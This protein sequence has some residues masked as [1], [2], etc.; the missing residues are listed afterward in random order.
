[1]CTVA[2]FGGILLT[3]AHTT[4]TTTAEQ[5]KPKPVKT[6]I[7]G[8]GSAL[9]LEPGALLA[10]SLVD[11]RPTYPVVSPALEKITGQ[12]ADIVTP[13]DRPDATEITLPWQYPTAKKIVLGYEQGGLIS[14]HFQRFLDFAAR[15]LDV[16]ITNECNSA[17]TLITNVIRKDKLCFGPRAVLNFHKASYADGKVSM[18]D[19]LRMFDLY[20][21]DIRDWINARGGVEKLP[22]GWAARPL[23][24]SLPASELWKMGC[25]KCP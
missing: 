4:C 24:W 6:I 3:L 22:Q 10:P 19:T 9:G 14:G 7:V 2:L 13:L 11:P 17:C 5:D 18:E 16:E 15:N 21:Q 12:P 1:M 8:S 25:R 20:P 23:Y